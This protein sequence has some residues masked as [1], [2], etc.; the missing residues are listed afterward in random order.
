MAKYTLTPTGRYEN[1]KY[2]IERF[3]NDALGSTH[4]IAWEG[5][6]FESSVSQFIM[7]S[8][9]D[10]GESMFHRQ[11]ASSGAEIRGK[12]T[13]IHIGMDV[14]V[15]KVETTKTNRH[16]EI[17]GRILENMKVGS[18]VTLYDF[19]SG[20]TTN[21]LGV[22]KIRE[23]VSARPI[24]DPDY[25]RFNLEISVDWLQEWSID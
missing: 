23:V 21:S 15:K 14:Y 1:F 16:Y 7:Q 4:T 24:P 3:I 13:P 9:V 8:I 12:T 2:S 25:H 18:G 11:S 19:F 5:A 22:M 6:P 17:A 10:E 20:N